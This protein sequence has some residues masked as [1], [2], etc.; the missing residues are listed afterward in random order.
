MFSLSLQINFSNLICISVNSNYFSFIF[1]LIMSFL[2]FL[3]FQ[4]KL[5]TSFCERETKTI[6][7]HQN[8][9]LNLIDVNK[10]SK[11]E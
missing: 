7:S 5:I 2:D 4:M 10:N 6:D 1:S 8:D 9:R 11:F 3:I